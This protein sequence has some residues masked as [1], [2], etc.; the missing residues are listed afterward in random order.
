MTPQTWEFST[1]VI[2][3][4]VYDAMDKYVHVEK[5]HKDDNMTFNLYDW[6]VQ[7]PHHSFYC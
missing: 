3:Y 1:T 5:M 4:T 6:H 7:S 2:E